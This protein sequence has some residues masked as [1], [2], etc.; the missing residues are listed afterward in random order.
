LQAVMPQPMFNTVGFGDMLKLNQ[1]RVSF[2]MELTE[3]QTVLMA[4]YL[5]SLLRELCHGSDRYVGVDP[6]V[7]HSTGGWRVGQHSQYR[8]WA[9]ALLAP[10][11]QQPPTGVRLGS[12]QI[13][14]P[15][16][17]HSRTTTRSAKAASGCGELFVTT[18]RTCFHCRSRVACDISTW[19]G[20]ISLRATWRRL[21]S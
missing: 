8:C 12:Q 4:R 5:G 13:R 21:S 17:G 1:N 2:V 7:H 18:A 15:T 10:Q 19:L 16:S 11:N 6:L 14:Q 9:P 3:V 20:L